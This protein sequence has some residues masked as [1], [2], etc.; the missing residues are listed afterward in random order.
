MSSNSPGRA[1]RPRPLPKGNTLFTPDATQSR[2]E[3]E[4]RSATALL[5]M[6]QM[7]RWLMPLLAGALLLVGITVSGWGGAIALLA[8]AVMLGW[9]AAISWPRLPAQGRLLR[10]GI[11]GAV[12]AIALV[13]GF[14]AG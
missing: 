7:P 4:Q 14:H 1:R 9:L 5:W 13:R 11:I 2:Q 8:V 3:L 12:V 6:H 10:V